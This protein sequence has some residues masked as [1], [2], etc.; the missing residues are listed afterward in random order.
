MSNLFERNRR[1]IAAIFLSALFGMSRFSAREIFASLKM[2][3][4]ALLSKKGK[5]SKQIYHRRMKHCMRCPLWFPGTMTC[6]SPLV[7]LKLGCHCYLPLKNSLSEATCWVNHNTELDFGWPKELELNKP[8]HNV[9]ES[10]SQ[11]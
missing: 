4:T 9:A 10:E 11:R 7:N 1:F 3:M 8:D 6:G 2:M 5:V